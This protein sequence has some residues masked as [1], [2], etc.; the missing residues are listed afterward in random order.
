MNELYKFFQK[1]LGVSEEEKPERDDE[2]VWNMAE[3]LLWR[4]EEVSPASIPAPIKEQPDANRYYD[5]ALYM[6]NFV[7]GKMKDV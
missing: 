3:A 5:D 4:D 1:F 2:F 7:K 6:I